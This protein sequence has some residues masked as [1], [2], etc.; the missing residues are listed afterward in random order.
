MK[1]SVVWQHHNMSRSKKQQKVN[2]SE[3]AGIATLA[4]LDLEDDDTGFQGFDWSFL[5]CC[6]YF[7]W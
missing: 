5:H 1:K 7:S 2:E 6:S 4:M 3:Y